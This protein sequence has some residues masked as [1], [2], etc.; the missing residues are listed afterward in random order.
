MLRSIAILASLTILVLQLGCSGAGS[1]TS[2]GNTY[3]ESLGSTSRAQIFKTTDDI[4][5]RKFQY[6][7]ERQQDSSEDVYIETRWR[8]Q[9]A[10][11][12]E[13]AQGYA[14]VRTRIILSARPR[15]RTPGAMQSY[16][17]TFRSEC[18]VRQHGGDWVKMPMTA[19]RKAQLREIAQEMKTDMT[20]GVR[21]I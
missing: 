2:S 3:R 13:Q 16:S 11:E 20:S 21:V 8:D 5:V 7:F 18:M 9:V 4:L 17:V 19:M 6:Q 1:S 12:D 10:L 14:F 15:N